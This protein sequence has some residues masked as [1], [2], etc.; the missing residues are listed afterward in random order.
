MSMDLGES[1]RLAFWLVVLVVSIH[2]A[3]S[4][5]AARCTRGPAR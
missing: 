5:T 1:V 3:L 2:P 4:A